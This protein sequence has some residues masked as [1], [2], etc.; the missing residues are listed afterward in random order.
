MKKICY[1]PIIVLSFACNNT[2]KEAKQEVPQVVQ[3]K[4]NSKLVASWSNDKAKDSVIS[5][6]TDGK[7][8]G[9]A[10]DAKQYNNWSLVGADTLILSNATTKDTF[11]VG[12]LTE[13]DL[14]ITKGD[15]VTGTTNSFKKK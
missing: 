4:E 11:M 1:L 3:T 8:S 12:K 15:Y 10:I 6:S 7:V 13:T 14:E 5:F 2:N 9:A